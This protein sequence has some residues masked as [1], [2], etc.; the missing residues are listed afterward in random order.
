MT[1]YAEVIPG[2]R[3]LDKG[4]ELLNKAESEGD[5]RGAVVALREVRASLESIDAMLSRADEAK[6]AEQRSQISVVVNPYIDAAKSGD[7]VS[8]VRA[9]SPNSR[10]SGHQ[11]PT[12][13]VPALPSSATEAGSESCAIVPL[14]RPRPMGSIVRYL[15]GMR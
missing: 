11:Q 12:E 8:P 3:V 2:D 5:T 7:H 9:V 1:G 10:D 14:R 6:R 4:W 13:P 15:Q